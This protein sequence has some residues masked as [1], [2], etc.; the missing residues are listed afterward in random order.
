MLT[1]FPSSS[2]Q[3]FIYFFFYESKRSRLGLPAMCKLSPVASVFLEHVVS[4]RSVMPIAATWLAAAA[5]RGGLLENEAARA[6][7]ATNSA[8]V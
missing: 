6:A 1:R 8:D 7:V 2:F 3:F 4:S 5:P